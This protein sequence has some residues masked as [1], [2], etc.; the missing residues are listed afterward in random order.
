VTT[1]IYTVTG[2]TCGHCAATVTEE[3][4]AVAGVEAV[5]VDLQRATATV[6]G[7]AKPAALAAILAA[8]GYGLEP[9]APGDRP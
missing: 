4:A 7:T 9:P 3:L 5:A 1:T 2:M 6:T 8:V